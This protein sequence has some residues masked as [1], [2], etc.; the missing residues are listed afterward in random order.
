V[1]GVELTKVGQRA[2]IAFAGALVATTLALWVAALVGWPRLAA[3]LADAR[4]PRALYDALGPWVGIALGVAL[5]GYAV[6][7]V[8]F[9]SKGERNHSIG[10]VALALATLVALQAAFHGSDVFRATRSSADLVATLENASNPPYDRNAPFFQ[11]RMYDQ[12]LPFYLGRTTTL[13][14]YRDELGLGLDIEPQLGIER[15]PDWI[16]QWR[17]LH[18]GY[19][20]MSPETRAKLDAEGVP[21]RVVASDSRRTLV[22]RR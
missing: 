2:L 20:L 9:A 18:Q 16:Q 11:V 15:V 19:A 14:D 12:T 6:A 3:A 8:A 17:S 1:L 5:A 10:V 22:A 7:L 4:T 21:M 13:V